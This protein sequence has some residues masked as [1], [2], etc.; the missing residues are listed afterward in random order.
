MSNNTE[1]DPLWKQQWKTLGIRYLGKDGTGHIDAMD[2]F[3]HAYMI[4][5]RDGINRCKEIVDLVSNQ[6]GKEH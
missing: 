4:G 3:E 1:K 6:I 2:R 5:Y